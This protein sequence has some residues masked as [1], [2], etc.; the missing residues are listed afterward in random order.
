MSDSLNILKDGVKKSRNQVQD[1]IQQLE[2]LRNNIVQ[3]TIFKVKNHWIEQLQ[4]HN[5]YSNPTIEAIRVS[6]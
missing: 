5:D 6:N 1:N 4:R 2:R 3:D